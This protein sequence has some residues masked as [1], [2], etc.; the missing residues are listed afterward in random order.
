MTQL[1]PAFE[2]LLPGHNTAPPTSQQTSTNP[3]IATTD[4]P[5][6]PVV[7]VPVLTTSDS[8]AS[9]AHHTSVDDSVGVEHRG[10]DFPAR[11]RLRLPSEDGERGFPTDQ[12]IDDFLDQL[13]Q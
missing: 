13:H 8:H 12:D 6:T 5:Q 10:E 11:K 3:P 9:A 2:G 1:E 4:H 7:P